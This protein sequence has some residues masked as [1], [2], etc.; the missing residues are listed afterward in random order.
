MIDEVQSLLDGYWRWLKDQTSL[1]EVRDYIEITT[2]FLD[3]HND[4][5]QI[6]ARRHDGGF[7]L[8]DDG[9]TVADLEQSG[10]TID[11]P[12]RQGLLRATLNGFGVQISE[13]SKQ[14]EVRASASNFALRKHNL[15]QAMLAV[16]DL[17]YLASPTV[18]SLFYEDV[19][20]WLDTG[21]IRY[22]PNVR[23]AGRSGYDHRF[24][25]VIPKSKLRP[26]RVLR[27]INR[28]SR[29]TA[30]TMTFAWLDTREV[31]SPDAQ[32]YAI[33]NDSEI[34]ISQSVLDAMR[35]YEVQPIPWSNRERAREDL[36]A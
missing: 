15:V 5:L 13:T 10:C 20:A 31:R 30:Q 4:F 32:A 28:P 8:T 12:K 18:L 22:T 34:P 11:S 17:F 19:V 7:I 24:D 21:D 2:P 25:F 14:L 1:R 6:Y 27:A 33:L 29:E 23:F 26:E 35:N 36:A 16:N 3:R 9:Y